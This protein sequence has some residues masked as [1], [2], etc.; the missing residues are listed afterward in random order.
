MKRIILF[1]FAVT[2]TMWSISII[3]CE[4]QT[5]KYTDEY[6]LEACNSN[7]MIGHLDTLKVLDYEPYSYCKV[8]GKTRNTGHIFIL[9]YNGSIEQPSWTV[10]YWNT[11]WSDEGSASGFVYPYIR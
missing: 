1:M 8:Y 5:R 4:I 2:L 6:L 3:H 7:N 10:V 9:L 11:I